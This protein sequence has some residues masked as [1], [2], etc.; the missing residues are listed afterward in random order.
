MEAIG[1][2]TILVRQL[3]SEQNVS[4]PAAKRNQKQQ[5][6]LTGR[7]RAGPTGSMLLEVYL[8]SRF[9]DLEVANCKQYFERKIDNKI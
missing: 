6:W 1:A 2:E 7:E 5:F 3:T 4:F 9:I 8:V